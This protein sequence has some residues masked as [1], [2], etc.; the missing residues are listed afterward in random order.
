MSGGTTIANEIRRL[1]ERLGGTPICDAC[2]TERLHLSVPAQANV[3]TRAL[4]G[5]D[6]FERGK[7]ACGACGKPRTAIR[8]RV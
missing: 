2:I 5:G 4:G 7:I 6:D 8:C 1:I 3:V